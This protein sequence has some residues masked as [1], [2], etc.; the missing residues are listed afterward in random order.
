MKRKIQVGIILWR[1]YFINILY[2]NDNVHLT[3]L[4]SGSM[5]PV[6]LKTMSQSPQIPRQ[7]HPCIYDASGFLGKI[8]NVGPWYYRITNPDPSDKILIHTYIYIRVFQKYMIL[9]RSPFFDVARVSYSETFRLAKFRLFSK[10]FRVR[11]ELS[12]FPIGLT[13]EER[14]DDQDDP[15]SSSILYSP[16]CRLHSLRTESPWCW[17][18]LCQS[19]T[20]RKSM[21][22]NIDLITLAIGGYRQFECFDYCW[23]RL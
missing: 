12:I 8:V 13:L 18:R 15:F 21:P 1:W 6:D 10:A 14:Y 20:G 22:I 11:P 3:I 4:G 9:W 23:I 2:T 5:I 17:C 19:K 16:F 7:N